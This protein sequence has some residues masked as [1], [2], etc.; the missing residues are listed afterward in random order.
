MIWQSRS[1]YSEQLSMLLAMHA[2]PVLRGSKISNI[3][4]IRRADLKPILRLLQGTGLCFASI[5]SMDE[6][7][8][9]LLYRRRETEAYLRE[10][11]VREILRQE[12][13][14]LENSGIPH[15][16]T[17]LSR[18]IRNGRKSGNCFPH[19]IGVFLGY[20]PEDVKGFIENKGAACKLSGYWK[21]YGDPEE[22]ACLF[23][24]FDED[25]DYAMDQVARGIPI[26]EIAVSF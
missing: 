6:K 11:A 22:A 17:Q 3:V 20:P 18:R 19:E 16:L 9:L 24:R 2:A 10:D 5:G 7:T 8:I 13:Y 15:L 4:T 12:G 14:E 25:K 1:D 23:R 21:V 26:R